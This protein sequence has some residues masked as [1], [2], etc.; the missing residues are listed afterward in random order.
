MAGSRAEDRSFRDIAISLRASSTQRSLIDRAA[1]ATGKT[2]S[3]FMLDAACR[4]AEAALLDRRIFVLD[5]ADFAA[6]EARLNESPSDESGLRR[7]LTTPSP[8]ER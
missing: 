1:A 3:E 2:R 5:D 7:L 6:F 8:W 4:E